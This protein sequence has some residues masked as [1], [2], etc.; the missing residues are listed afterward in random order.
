V[1]FEVRAGNGQVG[2]IGETLSTTSTITSDGDGLAALDVWQLGTVPD[3]VNCVVARL[4]SG[5]AGEITFFAT[6]IDLP[7]V[8]EVWPP[9]GHELS[10]IDLDRLR[11]RERGLYIKFTHIMSGDNLSDPDP[12]LRLWQVISQDE[13][14]PVMVTRVELTRLT[15]GGTSP[16]SDSEDVSYGLPEGVVPDPNIAFPPMSFLLMIESE[17]DRIVDVQ[18]VMLDADYAGTKLQFSATGLWRGDLTH[19]ITLLQALW[20]M[21]PNDLRQ[22]EASILDQ[23]SNTTAP[24]LPF[25]GDGVSGGRF[26]SWFT[27]GAINPDASEIQPS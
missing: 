9:N 5:E 8:H 27:L 1:I 10:S 16:L 23:L 15:S 12:W 22:F 6:P 19:T 13:G 4:A 25:S 24:S 17:Q 14:T 2:R 21:P 3:Q 20:D 7:R 18:Q 11:D 26:H